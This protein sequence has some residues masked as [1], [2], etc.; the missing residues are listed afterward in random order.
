MIVHIISSLLIVLII[1]ACNNSKHIN[2][3]TVT[4]QPDTTSL[5]RNPGM[6][7]TIYDDAGKLVADADEYWEQQDTIARKY[8]TTLYIRWRWSDMETEEGTYAWEYDDNFN[9]LAA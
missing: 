6:G 5:I 9:K 3:T 1:S 8:A 4:F 2:L 7:W